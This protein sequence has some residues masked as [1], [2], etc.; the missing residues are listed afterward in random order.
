[1]T[2]R[3]G[4]IARLALVLL[5]AVPLSGCGIALMADILTHKKNER[6]WACQERPQRG[7]CRQ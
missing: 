7:D 6:F 5:L 1:M 2:T 3:R 4:V